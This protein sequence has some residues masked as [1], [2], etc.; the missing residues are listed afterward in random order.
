MQNMH[1]TIHRR[2]LI[3]EMQMAVL[4]NGV[5]WGVFTGVLGFS[6]L[7]DWQAWAIIIAGNIAYSMGRL[8]NN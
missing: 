1:T 8:N 3:K 5:F 6:V 7:G 2:Q 4:L